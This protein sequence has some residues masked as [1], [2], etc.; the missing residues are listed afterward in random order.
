[1]NLDWNNFFVV[2]HD[3]DQYQYHDHVEVMYGQDY[4][5]YSDHSDYLDYPIVFQVYPNHHPRRVPNY[6]Y[7]SCLLMVHYLLMK[8]MASLLLDIDLDFDF[9]LYLHLHLH[10]D[11]LSKPL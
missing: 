9:D 6:S 8:D 7:Y 3:Q 11:H 2:V 10:L 1:M 4:L 5:D